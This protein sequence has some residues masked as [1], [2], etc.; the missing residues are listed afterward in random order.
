VAFKVKVAE[1]Q[2]GE[3]RVALTDDTACR[4]PAQRLRHF[5][6]EQVRHMQRQR[7]ARDA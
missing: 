2:Q 4:A 1:G 5:D 6:I 3:R 7:G